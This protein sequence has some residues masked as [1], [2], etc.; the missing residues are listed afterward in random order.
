MWVYLLIYIFIFN[1]YLSLLCFKVIVLHSFTLSTKKEEPEWFLWSQGKSWLHSEFLVIR[2]YVV[3]NWKTF[4]LFIWLSFKLDLSW[5]CKVFLSLF[6]FNF[7]HFFQI[8]W[9]KVIAI[10]L[11][12]PLFLPQGCICVVF[13]WRRLVS[14]HLIY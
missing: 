5:F 13:S 11:I 10:S 7:F 9:H 8:H 14:M 6:C 4:S 2:D 12:P 1:I 3:S